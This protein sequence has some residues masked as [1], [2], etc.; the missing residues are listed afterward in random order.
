VQITASKQIADSHGDK[1]FDRFP[2]FYERDNRQH[3]GRNP[4]TKGVL[5]AKFDTLLPPWLVKGKTVLDLGAC[6]GAAGQWALFYGA[7]S[8]TGVE[9]QTGYVSIARELLSPWGDQA[10]IAQADIRSYLAELSDKSYDIILAAG[11]IYFFVDPDVVVREMCRVAKETVLIESNYP[12]LIKRHKLY[13][14][15]LMLVEY[16]FGQ[17]LNMADGNYSLSGLAASPSVGALDLFFL[18]NGFANREGVLKFPVTADSLVYSEYAQIDDKL[19]ARFAARYFRTDKINAVRSLEQNIPEALGVRRDWD[20]DKLYAQGKDLYQERAQTVAHEITPWKFDDAVANSFERI[21]DTSIPH[22]RDVI[23][24]T[25]NIIKKSG[26]ANPKIIDVGSAVGTTLKRLNEA[27]FT[28]LYGVDSSES[29]LQ[30][31]FDK[32][33]L[34]HS[35]Q[36]P[37][38]H[39]PFDVVIANW[40]LHFI[41][42]RERYLE[43]IRTSMTSGGLLILSEKVISSP[44]AHDLYYDFKRSNGLTEEEIHKKQQQLAGVLTPYPLTWYIETLYGLGFKSVD[45]VDAHYSFVTIMAQL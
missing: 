17:D 34:I 27:G 37:A 7:K 25:I 11:V 22:Y 28:N 39:G 33:V 16:I 38:S 12:E 35:E 26:K 45:V 20:T 18:L 19:P 23:E 32:A 44:L 31:S 13:C 4:I 5:E 10:K 15:K 21:A 3:R 43:S 36:F 29:M 41:R 8:Y 30:R 40:V 9:L 1:P 24:K 42:D 6:L 14:S 2:G